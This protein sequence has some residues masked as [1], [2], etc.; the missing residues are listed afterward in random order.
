ME[1]IHFVHYKA[2]Y[3]DAGSAMKHTDGLAVVGVFLQARHEF[4]NQNHIEFLFVRKLLV[5]TTYSSTISFS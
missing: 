5:R 4:Y 2:S 3:G 1:Q